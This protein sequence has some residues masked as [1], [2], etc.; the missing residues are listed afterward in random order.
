[1]TA[2]AAKNGKA[3]GGPT[4]EESFP[5]E[6]FTAA[7]PH[8]RRPFTPEAVK[9]KVQ[10]T[11][12]GGALAVAYIDARLV[13]ERLN[14]I[15]PHLWSDHYRPVS[16][17]RMWCDLTLDGITRSDVGEGNGKGLVSDALKRAAVK[18][19]I[20]VSLYATPKMFLDE[21]D[22]HLKPNNREKYV[23]TD[24]GERH[25]REIYRQWLAGHG[26]KAFG[27]ALDHGDVE[28]SQGDAEVGETPAT[29]AS[30]PTTA[31]PAKDRGEDGLVAVAEQVVTSGALTKRK[32]ITV[33]QAHGATD[34]S[35]V[36]AAMRSLP[37]EDALTA[38][39]AELAKALEATEVTA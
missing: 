24:N 8:M 17:T 2:T 28:D 12:D 18:F 10:A 31:Q 27:P 9:F 3:A 7:A 39:G 15:C 20:G 33:L 13:V 22:G 6:S 36:T 37:D 4:V 35:S 5:V 21:R 23:L 29:P 16:E 32:L 1:M 14:L 11:W 34:T 25:C 19:G 30:T 26:I 38:V